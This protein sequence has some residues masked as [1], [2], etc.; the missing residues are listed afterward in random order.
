MIL[1]PLLNESKAAD[2]LG[3]SPKT[4]SGWRWSGKG[5]SYRKLESA[6]RY[7]I[8]DLDEFLANGKV[9]RHGQ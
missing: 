6:V 5:P 9:G 7:A 8:T 3:I 4:L 2:Y 1:S